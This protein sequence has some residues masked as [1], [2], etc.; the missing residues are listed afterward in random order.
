MLPIIDTLTP[1]P[2]YLPPAIP[3]D[4]APRLIRL[5]SQ[6]VVWWIGQML[7]FLLRPQPGTEKF[8]NNAKESLKFKSP[9][10]GYVNNT[11]IG[12]TDRIVFLFFVLNYFNPSSLSYRQNKPND[13]EVPK[14]VF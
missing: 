9:I 12:V 10:V 3:E 5:H 6:P 13:V 4:L 7:R 14:P 2:D 8:L 11:F 1:R